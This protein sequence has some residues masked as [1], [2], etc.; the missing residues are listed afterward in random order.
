MFP[1]FILDNFEGFETVVLEL[2]TVFNMKGN[3]GR[4][5]RVLCLV[6]TGNRNGLAGFAMGK[7][8]E[9]RIAMR[10]A[11]NRAGQKLMHIKIFRGNTVFH[12]FFTQFGSTKIY[13]TSQPEG[14]GL[15]CHRAI[16]SIC[17]IIGIKDLHAKIEG[18]TN[19]NHIMKAFFLGLIRQKTH[20]QIAEEKQLHLVE[21]SKENGYFPNVLASPAKCRT[22]DEIPKD[23]NLDF[24]QYCYDGRVV[25]KKKKIPPFYA[26]YKSYELYLRKQEYTRNKYDMKINLIAEYGEIRSFYTDQYPECRSYKKP[27]KEPEEE[28]M[29]EEA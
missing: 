16:K 29:E 20:E 4:K 2:K 17:Q 24:S 5:R 26:N 23:E 3:F 25:L 18:S 14:H 1:L 22:A 15:V 7:A 8:V 19:V 13:V 12:D 11:K 28:T 6:V 10:K 27:P 9:P 21:F